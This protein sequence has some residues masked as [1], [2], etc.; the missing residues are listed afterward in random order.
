MKVPFLD[1]QALTQLVRPELDQAYKRVLDSGWFIQGLECEQFEA[2]FATYTQSK[3]CIGVGNGLDALRLI[4]LGYGIGPGDEVLVPSQTFIATWLAVSETGA[5]P[6][7]VDINP[8]TYNIDPALVEKVI[9]PKTKAVIPV[10]LYGQPADMDPIITVAKKHQLKVIE[11]A[12]QAHGALYKNRPCGSLGDAAAFSFYPGKN[13]GAFGDGGAVTTHDPELAERIRVIGNYGSSKKY[14]HEIQGCNSRLDELQAAFLRV[15]LARL[16]DW[17]SQRRAIAEQ[18]TQHLPEPMP[19][20][21]PEWVHPAW[22]LYVIQTAHRDAL[23]KK[24][25]ESG[26]QTL[27]HYPIPPADQ[28]IY[29]NSTTSLAHGKTASESCLSLPIG[30]HLNSDQIEWVSQTIRIAEDSF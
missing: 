25:A 5:T 26:V 19:P 24:L 20:F 27:I 29:S 6:V 13:L 11:D 1:L 18:Y 10:H 21:A 17:T 23:Q 2:E 9:T 14:H 28:P 3:H 16:D 7:P 4:L 12:A 8:R 15:K 22:H 30:I